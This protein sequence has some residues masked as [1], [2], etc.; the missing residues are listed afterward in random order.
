VTGHARSGALPDNLDWRGLADPH[1]TLIFYMGGNTAQ[2]ISDRLIAAG[3]PAST[4]AHMVAGVTHA[5]ETRWN[6]SLRD[7]GVGLST[8]DRQLPILIG[9]GSAL[10]VVAH[11]NRDRDT[12]SALIEL[13]QSNSG[14][15]AYA[16]HSLRTA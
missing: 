16:S 5:H 3:L 9:V 10:A 8:M 2:L 11:D 13:D 15:L 1:T 7:L 6:G 14:R 4:P 12:Q